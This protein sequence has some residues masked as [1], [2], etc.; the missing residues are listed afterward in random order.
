MFGSLGKKNE[1]S[2]TGLRENLDCNKFAAKSSDNPTWNLGT[3]PSQ[4]S[5]S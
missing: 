5:Q 1:R 2:R 4:L 3:G